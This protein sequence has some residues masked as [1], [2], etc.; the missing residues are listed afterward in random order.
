MAESLYVM[1]VGSFKGEPIEEI[2]RW[3]LEAIL[4][5]DFFRSNKEG[6]EAVKKELQFRD[7]FGEP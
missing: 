1:K 2:P 5:C 4:D 3:Y 6:L 7:R